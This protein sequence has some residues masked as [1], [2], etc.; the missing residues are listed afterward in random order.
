MLLNLSRASGAYGGDHS[1]HPLLLGQGLGTQLLV[2]SVLL[3]R[4]WP[5]CQQGCRNLPRLAVGAQQVHLHHHR[6]GQPMTSRENQ[7]LSCS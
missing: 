7:A 3:H 5:S 1:S 4:I 6:L 2:S